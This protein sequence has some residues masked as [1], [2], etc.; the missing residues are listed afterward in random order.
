MTIRLR[1]NAPWIAAW[2][3]LASIGAVWLARAE[4]AHLRESFEVDARI[5]HRLLSQRASQHDAVLATLGLLQSQSTEAERERR[6]SSVYPQVISVEKRAPAAGWPSTGNDAALNAAEDASRAA[7]RPALG[8]VDFQ[9]GHYWIVLAAIPNSYALQIDA[10]AMVPWSDWP[11]G[12]AANE[13]RDSTVRVT[14]EHAGQSFVLQPGQIFDARWRFDF[15]KHLATASQPFDVV[16]ARCV[17]WAELPWLWMIAWALGTAALLV[18]LATLMHQR[19]ERARAEELLR[20]GQ[21]ARLNTLGEL[22][23]CMAH[24]LNQPL[25]AVLANTQAAV[26]L[27]KESPPEIDTAQTAMQRASEQARR[28][29]DV[30]TRLRRTVERPDMHAERVRVRLAEAVRDALYLLEPQCREHRVTTEMVS[31]GDGE[32][33]ADP[34]ALEQ[35][36][37]NLATNALHALDQM[38][39]DDRRLTLTISQTATHGELRIADN[40][41]G[42]AQDA[43]PRLFEP[44]FTTRTDG[45]GLG[46]GLSVCES[47]VTQMDGQ[48]SAQNR[49]PHGAEFTIALPLATRSVRSELVEP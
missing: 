4:L 28:A 2:V 12:N 32:V 33:L 36:I 42:I 47:L 25:T 34:V 10:R 19:R 41:P 14:L 35:V 24:E 11:T 48:I 17:S 37:H 13:G 49:S 44:F 23:A 5:M 26:R 43:L 38:Q 15:R 6:L 21:V 16:V 20:L 39:S 27:L 8:P 18:A 1:Q 3:A 7:S 22:A 9:Q 40:G 45:L 46:L 30:L 31:D 29:A